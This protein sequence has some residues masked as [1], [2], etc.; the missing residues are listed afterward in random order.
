MFIQENKYLLISTD[1]KCWCECIYN[2]LNVP[3][4]VCVMSGMCVC[5][6]V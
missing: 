4:S 1:K 2:R 6:C 5:V 3:V